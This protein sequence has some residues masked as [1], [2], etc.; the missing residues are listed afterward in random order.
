MM[1]RASASTEADL[2]LAATL[3]SLRQASE[4]W[5]RRE[6]A[7]IRVPSGVGEIDA[8]L[9][10]GWPQGK[11]GELVGSASSGR[12]AVA[13]AT[14]ASATTR[15]EVVAWIDA[16]DAFDPGSVA[17]AG[18]R[19]DR[20]LW[21]RSGGIEEAVRSAELVLETGGFTVVVLDLGAEVRTAP[22]RLWGSR[23]RPQWGGRP[24]PLQG[25]PALTLRLARAVE[26]AGAVALV[27]TERSWAGTLAGATVALE[28]GQAQWRGNEHGGPRWLAGIALR[29]RA[30]RGGVTHVARLPSA[31]VVASVG[32]RPAAEPA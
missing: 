15:G 12:T 26:R 23:P 2:E 3:T 8:L 22:Q 21:V 18:V 14:M 19:L 5:V 32:A 29:V 11:V 28:R 7:R 31:V 1:S 25:K 20:V 30:D 10:G 6:R 4:R 17:G 9:G 24:R 16:A 27:L 13:A